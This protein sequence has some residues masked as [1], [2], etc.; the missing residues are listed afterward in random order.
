MFSLA[1]GCGDDVD[2]ADAGRDAGVERD[3]GPAVDS[4]SG[5]DAG[6]LDAGPPR[7]GGPAMTGDYEGFGAA[8]M[9]AE[10]SPDGFDTCHVTSLDDDGAG[11]LR[12]CVSAGRRMV[13]FDLGGTITLASDLNIPHSYIT[14]AGETA[15]DPGITIVQPSD[16]GTTIEARSRI[17]EAHDIVIRYLRMDGQAVVHE[18][19]GDIWGLDGESAPVHHIVID[20]VTGIAS[21]DGVFDIWEDVAD[22]TIS[23]C[24]I[25][26]TVTALHLSA[27]AGGTRERISFHHNVFARNNERQVRLR[28]DNRT[29]DF[30]N[31]V[32][33]GWGWIEGGGYGLRIVHDAGE[34]NTSVNVIGNVFH[35]LSG[36]PGSA[37]EDDAIQFDPGPDR[38][39]VF[40]SGNLVPS[41]EGDDSMSTR[42]TPI[43]IPPAAAVTIY[44]AAELDT[45][46][47]PF[48]GTRFP[49]TEE[50][51]LLDGIASAIP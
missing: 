38:G 32:I 24:L 11:T 37:D 19:A 10:S 20:H 46:V 4:G 16:I 6:P 48:V 22:V 23:W 35:F 15:P 26:D 21:T 44:D 51:T 43:P 12:D 49:T 7:D 2:G 39:D 5:V 9:G 40:F 31:N 3:T 34:L 47:V 8:T 45:V 28:H 18:N 1:F 13:V 17:G 33:Y 25:L 42:R 30:V 14:V 41:G 50:R 36:L 29:I 27:S